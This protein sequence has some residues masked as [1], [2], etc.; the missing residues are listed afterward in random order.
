MKAEFEAQLVKRLKNAHRIE[1]SVQLL[2]A[3]MA[4]KASEPSRIRRLESRGL[5]A[6]HHKQR[7]LERLQSH[8]ERPPEDP[9]P[10]HGGVRWDE[11]AAPAPKRPQESG[12]S[13]LI[14]RL[15]ASYELLEATANGAGDLETARVAGLNRSEYQAFVGVLFADHFDCSA[16]LPRLR[17]PAAPR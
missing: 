2:L 15:I 3:H 10:K 13:L 8:G 7:L 1:S 6:R 11:T 9:T 5:E 14:A 4:E 17:A 12:G 16:P